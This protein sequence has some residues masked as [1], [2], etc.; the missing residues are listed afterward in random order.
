MA[1]FMDFLLELLKW[2]V[3]CL[4]VL[5]LPALIHA[6]ENF[7]L[8]NLRFFSFVGGAF[9]YLALKVLASSR[10][11]LSMQILAHELT[12]TF[13][14]LLTFHK[15]VHVHLNMDESGGSMGFMGKG[16]WLITIAPYFFPLF[17][18]FLMMFATF[19]ADMIPDSLMVNCVFGYFFAYHLESIVVQIHIEQPDFKEVGFFFCWLFLPAANLFSCSVVLAFNNGGWLGVEHYLVAV[20]KFG[21]YDVANVLRYFTN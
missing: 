21:V 2:P 1:R 6:L 15:V 19:F 5:L 14:A 20:Y 8:G 11:N 16:N 9:L 4:A 17:L 7:Q 10:S 18:F 12:H 3:V 13:F